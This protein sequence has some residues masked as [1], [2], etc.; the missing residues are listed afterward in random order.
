MTA[1]TAAEGATPADEETQTRRLLAAV[2]SIASVVED[3][4]SESDRQ[5]QLTDKT[6]TAL[7]DHGFWRMRLCRELGGMELTVA[8]QIRVLAAL[9]A[10][11]TSSAWCT[12]VANSA[13]ATLGATMSQ[14]AVERIFASGVPACSVAA[15]PAGVAIPGTD[16]YRL[17]GTWRLASSIHHA[18]WLHA[19]VFVDG[20]PS[21]PL[22]VAIPA[23]D[24]EVLDTWHV[25]GLAGT[26]S[27]DFTLTDY[28]LPP[29]LVGRAG[30]PRD[31]LR[32]SRRY[33]LLALDDLESCEHLAF[34]IGVAR[35][36]LDE[37]LA[38]LSRGPFGAFGDREVVQVQLG[39][40]MVSLEAMEATAHAVYKRVDAAAAGDASAWSEAERHLPRAVS[41]W[42]TKRALEVVQLAFQ[43]SGGAALHR[44]N[45]FEKLLRD[46]S[47]AAT[48][49]MVDDGALAA[50]AHRNLEFKG[51]TE[52]PVR[53]RRAS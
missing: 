10:V 29:E 31:L 11:D 49:V 52:P 2:D 53:M 3:G 22:P 25:V 36:A 39:E 33:D 23:H 32:G 9:A 20:D 51:S 18:E 7:R 44:P 12:M 45:I 37:L 47:V 15:A 48:H 24:V 30:N 26:G 42:A 19:V 34:A 41:V 13:V 28:Q 4:A 5:G 21:R 27:N 38:V 14:S 8:S 1:A 35:R 46:M 16:G 50:H 40:A 43:R 6:V 17:T